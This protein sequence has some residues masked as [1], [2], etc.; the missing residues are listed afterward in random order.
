MKTPTLVQPFEWRDN[1]LVLLDQT[2]LPAAEVYLT[3]TDYKQVATAI[4]TLQVRGAPAIGVAGGYGVALGALQM[5]AK[6]RPAFLAHLHEVCLTLA[7][8]RPTARNLFWAIERVEKA[9]HAP[10]NIEEI[11]K[12]VI[13]E[14]VAI[15]AEEVEATRLLSRHG[16]RLIKKGMTILTH[17]NTGPLAAPGWGTAL[18]VIIYAHCQGKKVHVYADETRP[19]LQGARLTTWELM[20]AGVLVTLI[21]D[22]MAGSFL[23]RGKIDCVIV[24]AD[25]IAA[26]GDTANKIGT[27]GVAVLAKENGVPFYVAAPTSTIDMRLKSGDDIIIE[28]RRPEEVTHFGGVATAPEGVSVANPAFDVTP[29]RYITAFVTEKGI[30]RKPYA[31]SIR[32]ELS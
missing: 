14:A 28:Q 30:M 7:G 19:L 2:R 11:R 20:K 27:Y 18:G 13:D 23:G 10:E 15:H 31:R 4:K 12:A 9:A 22:S 21:T 5:K 24:G 6:T 8:T 16:A 26:N 29:A 17:C 32:E 25:T 3:L 1:T